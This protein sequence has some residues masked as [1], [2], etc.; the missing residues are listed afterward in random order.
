[1]VTQIWM[2][3]KQIAK[4]TPGML[5]EPE[6]LINPKHLAKAFEAE[7]NSAWFLMEKINAQE[8]R[9]VGYSLHLPLRLAL[10]QQVK[11]GRYI[12]HNFTIKDLEPLKPGVPNFIYA[13]EVAAIPQ[14][15]S[16]LPSS[17]FFLKLERFFQDLE[18]RDYQLNYMA[19]VIS[20][21]PGSSD[22]GITLAKRMGMKLGAKYQGSPAKHPCFVYTREV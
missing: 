5:F 7:R 22:V 6:C 15:Y 19:S 3:C 20:S 10:F 9:V 18:D 17:R 13:F 14:L 4:W 8:S 2:V 16:S 1:M 11:A 21:I 12:E